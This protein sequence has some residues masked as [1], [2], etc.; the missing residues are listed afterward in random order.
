[1]ATTPLPDGRIAGAAQRARR[2]PHRRRRR[3]DPELPRRATR[4]HR[5]RRRR[6]DAAAHPSDAPPPRGAAG[7]RLDE[8]RSGLHALA[9]RCRASTAHPVDGR[10][11]GPRTRVAF[12][13][14]GQG[15]QWPSMGADAYDRLPRYRAEADRCAAA[16][17]TA[18]AVSPLTYLLADGPDRR[19]LPSRAPGRPV[20]ARRRVGRG[21]ALSR[22]A[23]R[24]H[25]RA[26]P[27]R[28]R[29]R[30]HRR[31][32][33]AAGRRR[34]GHRPCHPAGPP[35]RAVSRCGAG[36]HAR[37]GAG[38]DRPDARLARAVGGELQLVG[39]GVR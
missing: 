36:R 22:C 30:V 34:R 37:A 24:H 33:H 25:R 16:F 26:Q 38:S 7:R 27:R 1:M 20:R 9:S 21:V 5:R 13:F 11:G 10:R 29:C 15:S 28:D 6:G 14:P 19:V 17:E 31:N 12:V 39:R 23:A 35:H 8:L 18:G 32:H 4:G 2:R 3:R